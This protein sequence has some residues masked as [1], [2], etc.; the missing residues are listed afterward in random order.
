[1]TDIEALA[2]VEMWSRENRDNIRRLDELRAI[3]REAFSDLL[4]GAMYPTRPEE[5]PCILDC[6]GGGWRIRVV[7]KPGGSFGGA[8]SSLARA[9][10]QATPLA[11]KVLEEQRAIIAKVEAAIGAM[12]RPEHM[13]KS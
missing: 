8:M 9:V 1:M 10:E 3:L 11:E 7:D 2:R 13:E 4:G 6:R 12:H 5:V